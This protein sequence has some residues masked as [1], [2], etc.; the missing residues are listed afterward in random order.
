MRHPLLI[1]FLVLMGC[2]DG[3]EL[4]ASDQAAIGLPGG[5][6][7]PDEGSIVAEH[8]QGK[9]ILGSAPD[10]E[11]FDGAAHYHVL[12]DPVDPG[13]Q[14]YTI[15]VTSEKD[16]ANLRANPTGGG[17][18]HVGD[19]GWFVGLVLRGA[20]GGQIRIEA[21]TQRGTSSS[22]TY[23]LKH[24]SST[25]QPWASADYYC[26]GPDV[27][28]VALK[29]WYDRRRIHHD[30]DTITFS[31]DDGVATKCVDWEYIPGDLGESADPIN[32][33]NGWDRH[34]AC[35]AAANADYCRRGESL[36]RELTPILIRDYVAGA[37]PPPQG[38]LGPDGVVLPLVHPVQ[39]PGEPDR[40]YIEAAW[41]PR[42]LPP[43]CISRQRWTSLPLDPCAPTG[44]GPTD[45]D[46]PEKLRDPRVDPTAQTCE[47]FTFEQ[48]RKAGA[49]II[50]ASKMMDAPLYRWSN[51]DPQARDV[52]TTMR[53]FPAAGAAEVEPF[54]AAAGYTDYLGPEGMILR[55]LTGKLDDGADLVELYLWQRGNDRVIAGDA[56]ALARGFIEAERGPFEGYAFSDPAQVN[57]A[58][59]PLGVCANGGGD[60]VTLLDPPAAMACTPTGY[61]MRWPLP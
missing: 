28:A 51:P 55:N 11:L 43:I 3:P 56:A 48:L 52:V 44:P 16:G 40:Y 49:L 59:L 53:G 57:A 46:A 15:K 30:D 36:T 25:L 7:V 10:T 20:G 41:R 19:D 33:P 50:N 8:E 24:R 45:P 38:S 39:F 34:Q 17:A 31:C 22:T 47:D 6:E 13:H 58:L 2:T 4:D 14:G 12:P 26:G 21:A 37:A 60:L 32:S 1:S 5:G 35:T 42:G 18:S 23:I 27:G 54:G 9:F 29:G 61:A